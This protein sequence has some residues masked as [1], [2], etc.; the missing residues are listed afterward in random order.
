[1]LGLF[2][3]LLA[4]PARHPR[5]CRPGLEALEERAVPALLA[6][7]GVANSTDLHVNQGDIVG[8][9][10][11]SSRGG[12]SVVAWM[13]EGAT[14][15]WDI[16][17]QVYNPDHTPRGG[18]IRVAVSNAYET[19]PSVSMAN[20]GNWVISWTRYTDSGVKDVYAERFSS[21]GVPLGRPFAVAATG[22]A[23]NTSSVACAGNGDFVVAYTSQAPGSSNKDVLAKMYRADG[24][25]LRQFAVANSG[26]VEQNPAVAR[27]TGRDAGFSIAYQIGINIRL[28]TYSTT[29]ALTGN[30]VIVDT[31]NQARVPAVARD[32]AGDTVVTWQEATGT[33]TDL[34]GG[35]GPVWSVYARQVSARGVVGPVIHVFDGSQDFNTGF[36]DYVTPAVAM[37]PS[38]G[39]VVLA[40]DYTAGDM[41]VSWENVLGA[42]VSASG[43]IEDTYRLTANDFWNVGGQPTIPS[44]GIS[45]GGNYVLAYADLDPNAD[46]PAT[47]VYWRTGKL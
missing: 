34:N 6:P 40:E 15:D 30:Y 16:Y 44:V 33:F 35:N 20:N 39:F 37:K 21:M 29:G 27:G 12:L 18:E 46:Q 38:G 7:Q 8:T 25:Y 45:A 28:K 32:D 2:R 14:T 11:A 5:V 41:G 31:G 26:F 9:A 10:T 3:T 24:T 22:A 19:D 42:E 23:E 13:A 43:T 4:A 36:D 17:A 47:V 1:M